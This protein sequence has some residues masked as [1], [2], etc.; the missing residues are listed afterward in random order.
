LS[1]LEDFG[2]GSGIGLGECGGGLRQ[3]GQQRGEMV[4]AFHLI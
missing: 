4:V 3:Q 2:R 1:G